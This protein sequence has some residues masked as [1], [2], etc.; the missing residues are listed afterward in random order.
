VPP[1]PLERTERF[2]DSIAELDAARFVGR[3]D[4]LGP[5]DELMDRR[6]AGR[7]LF[8]HGPGG[9]GKSA[10]LREIA[11]RARTRRRDVRIVDGRLLEPS[12]LALAE[13]CGAPDGADGPVILID[14]FEQISALAG[15]LR[16][17]VLPALPADALVIIAGRARPGA[18][19]FRDGWEHVVHVLELSPLSDGDAEELL[20]RYGIGLMPGRGCGPGRRARRSPCTWPRPRRRNRC[21]GRRT[22]L[23]PWPAGWW[24]MTWPTSM[25]R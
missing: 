6:G 21:S 23:R 5:I 11:R 8:M 7:V 4:V 16:D 20:A 12:A 13:A 15:M 14:S 3:Q 25:P 9:I 1:E 24:A 19:W 2:A 10:L 18:T 22:W 17:Q